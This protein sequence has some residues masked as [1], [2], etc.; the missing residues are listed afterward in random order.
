MNSSPAL[1]LLLPSPTHAGW[2][3]AS[4]GFKTLCRTGA[5]QDVSKRRKPE[6]PIGGVQRKDCETVFPSLSLCMNWCILGCGNAP[7]APLWVSRRVQR[8]AKVERKL[9]AR[10][11]SV[12]KLMQVQDKRAL[13]AK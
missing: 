8:N 5:A 12:D 6:E 2:P 3:A 4:K 10:E 9:A 11:K 1:T 13:A 7:P